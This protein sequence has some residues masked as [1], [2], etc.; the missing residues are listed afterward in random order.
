M[1]ISMAIFILAAEKPKVFPFWH[2]QRRIYSKNTHSFITIFTEISDFSQRNISVLI[3]AWCDTIK[4]LSHK[5]SAQIASFSANGLP[6]SRQLKDLEEELGKQL[7]IRGSKKV[8]LT[9]DG[10]L[11]R[12][13]AEELVDLMEKTKC[14]IYKEQ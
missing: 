11:L 5:S 9:E 2:R 1:K 8:T 14:I 6:L 13:R 10:M 3:E 4:G 12:K 7:L